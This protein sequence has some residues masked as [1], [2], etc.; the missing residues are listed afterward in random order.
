MAE[1][2]DILTLLETRRNVLFAG[3]PGTGKSRLLS[4][5]AHLFEHLGLSSSPFYDPKADVPIPAKPVSSLPGDIGK[6]VNRKVFRCVLHQSSKYRDFLTGMMPDV[7]NGQPPGAFRITKGILY[8]ASE[9]AKQDESAAL[10]IIDEINRGPTVQVFGGAI[11]AIEADKRIGPD[12]KP[13]P[14]TQYFDL[15]NPDDGE[16]IKY[17]FPSRLYILAAMNQ[18]DVSV[19]PLDVAFLRRWT[20]YNLEPKSSILRD[21]YGLAGKPT[22]SL[23]ASPAKVEDVFEAAVQAFDAVNK[24]ITLGRGPEFRIGHGFLMG[25]DAK[26]DKIP[27]ALEHFAASW[28]T[29]KNHIDEAF[30]GDVRG[31]AIVLNA[32]RD[33]DGNPYSLEETSFGDAPRALINGPLTVEASAIYDLFLALAKETD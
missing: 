32:D 31:T 18:A 10:L 21:Y 24:R 29:M 1:A 16:L 22:A 19:E 25:S 5:V 13:T 23:P 28:R 7:R 12:G 20:P 4:E 3:P 8:Q 6:S 2:Q 33:I 30:F 26:P 14:A 15:T 11:V 9:Y 27:A 17:A